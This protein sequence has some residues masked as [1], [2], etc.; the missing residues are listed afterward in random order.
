MQPLITGK[1]GKARVETVQEDVLHL[2]NFFERGVSVFI[3]V[4]AFQ[5]E[6]VFDGK[7]GGMLR[8]VVFEHGS[9]NAAH[10]L[11]KAVVEVG[12]GVL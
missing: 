11:H 7:W 10:E 5:G 6:R 1:G 8:E 9:K 2:L 12:R 3:D 4:E